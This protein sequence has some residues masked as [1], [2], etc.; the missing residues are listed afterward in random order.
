[1]TTTSASV[2]FPRGGGLVNGFQRPVIS[3]TSITF[4]LAGKL[5][6]SGMGAGGSGARR[7]STGATTGG[8]SVPWGRKLVS[9]VAGQ[10]LAV[11][12][13]ASTAAPG[14]TGNGIAGSATIF[15]LDGVTIMTCNGAEGGI[16]AASGT[17]TAAA[18]AATVVGADF[19]QPGIRAGDGAALSGG[20]GGA[21]VDLLMMGAGRSGASSSTAG[22]AGGSVG[23]MAPVSTGAVVTAP[24]AFLA[25][26]E[27]GFAL[28]DQSIAL[29]PGRGGLGAQ[30]AIG[31][32]PG[33]PFGGGGGG[34]TAGAGYEKGG[35]GGWGAGG[36]AGS[37]SSLSGAPGQ[38]GQGYGYLIFV[39]GA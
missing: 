29:S 13:A 10:V 3:S 19:W 34:G 24:L 9:V 23:A 5:L 15:T 2:L 6:M 30:S 20:S 35:D 14:S 8:N 37:Y 7:G 25:L 27:L 21:A 33:G 36:G 4:P 32:N 26:A 39:A 22:T 16:Y 1:M 18:A 17:A 28:M 11:T 38:G 12:I 31:G